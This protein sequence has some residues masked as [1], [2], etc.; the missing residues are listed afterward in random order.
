M[1]KWIAI[2]CCLCTALSTAWGATLLSE[3]FDGMEAGTMPDGWSNTE[4]AGYYTNTTYSPVPP[5]LKLSADGQVVTSPT[6]AT[7]ATNVSFMGYSTGSGAG[8]IIAVAGLVGTEWVEIGQAVRAGKGKETNSFEV[9]DSQIT[10]LRFTFTK[11]A[12]ASLDDILVEGVED[13]LI[14]SFDQSSG[15]RVP[16]GTTSS[17]TASASNGT[18]PYS[19]SWAC[20]QSE[21]L[22]GGTDATLTIPDTLA[23]GEYTVTVTAT[24]AESVSASKSISFT[25]AEFYD[26]TCSYDDTLGSLYVDSTSA[27]EGDSVAVTATPADGYVL[28]S[29]SATW[30]EGTLEIA[31]GAFTMPAGAVTVTAVFEAYEAGDLS[32]TFDANAKTNPAYASTGFE[33]DGIAFDAL[34]CYGGDDG[35][36][37]CAM[38]VRHFGG[39]NGFFATASALSRPIARIKFAY[40]AYSETTA[41]TN[42]TWSL[43]TSTDGATWT[44][45][46]T[47]TAAA[48][49]QT[50]EIS[51]GIPDNSTYFRV[52]SANSG[53]TTRTAYFDNIEIWYGEA[54]Y[55]V[56]LSGA[57]NDER[58]VYDA[59]NPLVLTAAG[60]DGTEPYA[61]AWTVNGESA[62]NEA[63]CTFAEKGDYD[64]SV[65]CTDAAATETTATVNF[66]IEAQY[67]VTC[68]EELE[69]GTISADASAVFVG[70]TV[71]VTATPLDGYTLDGDITASWSGG[72]IEIV[73]GVFTMPEGDVTVSGAF[74]AVSATA[75]LPFEWHGPWADTISQLDGVTA[76]IATSD[77]ADSNYDAQGNGA[78]KFD[79]TGDYYQIA[80]SDAPDTLSYMIR[81]ASLSTENIST[82]TVQE[83]A[84]GSAWTEVAV[85]TSE[86]EGISSTLEVTN[87]LASDSRFVK[88]EY[89]TKGAGNFGVDAIVIAKAEG[90]GTVETTATLTAPIAVSGGNATLA[91]SLDQTVTLTADDIWVTDNLSDTGA[92]GQASGATV[93]ATESGYSIVV[94][95]AE[96][97]QYISVGKPK[98]L[99][100]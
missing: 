56:E 26:V 98:V 52:I 8:N 2:L 16:L 76:D 96:A 32:I 69:G 39:T 90:G 65:T 42:G 72:D 11:A 57:V 93:E 99:A 34:Q 33:S 82:F 83:S 58:V 70:D 86:T 95:V 23:A 71:T 53:S 100:E 25:V 1:K 67:A 77:Y 3:G 18:D 31:D 40:K 14:I 87:A 19:F 43:E 6:F 4:T 27:A 17:I 73:D 20:E 35:Q 85:Y 30:A 49:W 66:T 89:T 79:T 13:G 55:R 80:F 46:S 97:G 44:T 74:R 91:V 75:A 59:D 54:T 10:Q 12:N 63:T 60:A 94:P 48:D 24:D 64:V 47:V 50:E 41:N 81:G 9:A 88:F 22:D 84:D 61:Y 51:E 15:F 5:S 7:G 62:G 36:S 37:G 78:A 28:S 45:L 21:E 92:W 29:L 68:S 38:R